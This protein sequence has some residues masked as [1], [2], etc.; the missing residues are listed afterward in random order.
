MHVEQTDSTSLLALQHVKQGQA[1]PL[2]VLAAQ[3]QAGKGQAGRQWLSPRGN[4]YL[5]LAVC[6]QVRSCLS[7][8]VAALVCQW[9]R[10]KGIVASC[11]WPNDILYGGKKLGG[12]L[13]EGA[14]QGGQW[15]Y[16]IVGIGLNV[17]VVPPQLAA[18]AT[19]MR[20]ICGREGDVRQY[21]EQ[22]ARF[23]AA[24]L[25]KAVTEEEIISSY[26]RF[27]SAAPELWCRGDQFFVRE[28]HARGHLRL[29]SLAMGEI[30]ELTSSSP[31]YRLA[32]QQPHEEPFVAA[33]VGNSTIQLVLFKGDKVTL[34]A[35][36]LP[37]AYRLKGALRKVRKAISDKSEWVIYA[38][39]VNSAHGMLLGSLAEEMG[40]T[41]LVMENEPFRGQSDYD[42]QQLG[43]DRL[44]AV[45]A[46]LDTHDIETGIVTN[47]GTATTLDVVAEGCHLGG[48]ILPGLETSL[49]A[50]A[51]HTNLPSMSKR[52]FSDKGNDEL[53]S[54]TKNAMLRGV[55]HSQAAFVQQVATKHTPCKVVISGGLGLYV[56]PYLKEAVYEPLLVAKGIKALVLR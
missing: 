17:N 41:V 14:L 34:V 12:V 30:I 22:L 39:V 47:F 38:S 5:S 44:A 21:G 51:S 19:S 23:C 1:L 42:L 29:R 49:A 2:A 15:R 35:T 31:E 7:L 56:R 55:L 3:Q 4:L 25:D 36:A 18:Q 54:D 50:L 27:T 28:P 11:K 45:E 10:E 37:Q 33:D 24:R 16:V 13:C 48:Y 53:A 46:Y 9:L 20:A 32:Y 26:E 8:W 52:D 40:F 43:G 6:P